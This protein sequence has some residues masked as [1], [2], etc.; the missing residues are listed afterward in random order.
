MTCNDVLYLHPLAR[1]RWILD[2]SQE[3]GRQKHLTSGEMFSS[4]CLPLLPRC[5]Y[6]CIDDKE[7]LLMPQLSELGSLLVTQNLLSLTSWKTHPHLTLSQGAKVWLGK[8]PVKLFS[9]T[10]RSAFSISLLSRN[11]ALNEVRGRVQLC[12]LACYVHDR[13][14]K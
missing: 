7:K 10:H 13:C 12:H 1:P 6:R 8:G 11:P 2:L 9:E 14:E 5:S 3:Q 4:L